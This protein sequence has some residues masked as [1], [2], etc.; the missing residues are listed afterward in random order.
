[1]G[2]NYPVQKTKLLTMIVVLIGSDAIFFLLNFIRLV[3]QHLFNS[4]SYF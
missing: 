2:G 3:R 1:M 4:R